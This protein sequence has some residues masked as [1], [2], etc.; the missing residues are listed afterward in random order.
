M[1]KVMDYYFEK[2]IKGEKI[3]PEVIKNI[4][5]A[6]RAEGKKKSKE[7]KRQIDIQKRNL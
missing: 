7:Y 1:G 2:K 3:N 6:G 4:F 5:K